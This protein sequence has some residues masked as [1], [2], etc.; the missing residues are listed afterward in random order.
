[1]AGVTAA[2]IIAAKKQTLW[3]SVWGYYVITLLPVIGIIQVGGQSMADRYTYLPGIGPFLLI[4]LAAAWISIKWCAPNKRG[5]LLILFSAATAVL[6]FVSMSFLTVNQIGVWKNSLALWTYVVESHP[7]GVSIA[8]NNRGKVLLDMGRLIEASKDFDKAI[9]LD[10]SHYRA[11]YN[12]GITFDK[13]GR[14][15]EAIA[16]FD[17]AIVLNPSFRDAYYNRGIMYNKAGLFDNAIASFDKSLEIDPNDVDAYVNRGIS[18]ALIGQKDSA[19]EDFNKAI[20]L[21]QKYVLAYLNRGTLL[22]NAA[23]RELAMLDFQKACEL[24]NKEGCN[25][26]QV[27]QLSP[28]DQGRQ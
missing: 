10:P 17:M 13:M 14:P 7:A 2:C 21:N 9:A 4:G 19:Y 27:L 20:L 15:D 5:T 3:L 24:G 16:D 22:L 12:R 11:Y 1:V 18:Y 28:M 6:V 25:A 23:N 26:L 8:Y